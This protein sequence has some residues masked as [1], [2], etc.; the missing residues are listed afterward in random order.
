MRAFIQRVTRARVTVE[1]RVTGAI[2]RGLLVLLGATPTDRDVEADWLAHKIA[3]LRVF[4]DGGGHMNLDLAAI[5]GRVL[6]VPQF[7]LYGD[8]RRGRR[9]DFISAARPE[10]AEPLFERFCATLAAAGIDVE[11]GVF[12]AHMSVELVNDGPV[13]LLIESPPRTDASA[14]SASRGEAVGETDA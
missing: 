11:R 6:V 9:P 10:Q 3:G 2:E 12:R 14:P 5:G 7:T 13:S 1:G 4:A 8:A